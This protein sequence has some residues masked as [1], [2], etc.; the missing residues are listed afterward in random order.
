MIIAGKRKREIP[1]YSVFDV[2]S[3][4]PKKSQELYS[5]GITAVKDI[6]DDFR[7][8]RAP[9]TQGGC[10]EKSKHPY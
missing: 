4:S 6:P 9:T 2:F 8:D 5:K 7:Y 10:L 3:H 1:D